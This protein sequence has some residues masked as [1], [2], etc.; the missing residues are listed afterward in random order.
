MPLRQRLWPKQIQEWP[1]DVLRVSN[2]TSKFSAHEMV[3]PRQLAPQILRY[4]A[5]NAMHFHP[6][7]SV[8]T[9]NW[10]A[11]DPLPNN[12]RSIACTKVQGHERRDQWM[13]VKDHGAAE[14]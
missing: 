8:I 1:A 5:I 9:Q 13:V 4:H 6:A 11:I 2:G 14:R 3:R 7:A 12:G 10:A